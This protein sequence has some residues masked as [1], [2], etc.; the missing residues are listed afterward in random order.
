MSKPKMCK[1]K[2]KRV[3]IKICGLKRAEDVPLCHQFGVDMVGFVTEYPLPVLNLTAEKTKSFLEEV[4]PPLKSCLVTGGTCGKIIALAKDLHPHYIQLHYRETLTETEY[5]AKT[6]KQFGIGVIKTLPFSPSERLAC[7]G[8]E[9]LEECVRLLNSTA[10]D[11]ILA[12]SRGH[13]MLPKT[14][15]LSIS[16]FSG[17]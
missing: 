8:T 17:E 14:G 2:L 6:L 10:V 7:F 12:D 11:A 5:I 13:L 3:R 4:Q 16:A 9:E 15:P 1:E